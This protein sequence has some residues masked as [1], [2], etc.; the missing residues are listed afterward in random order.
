MTKAFLAMAAASTSVL[1]RGAL[2]ER[3]AR[4]LVYSGAP[5]KGL[6]ASHDDI[7]ISGAELETVAEAAGHFGGNHA[8]ARAE[9]RVIDQFAGPAVVDDRAAHRFD[10]LLRAMPPALLAPR[11]AE[12]IVVGKLPDRC[13]GAVAGPVAGLAL[14]HGVPAAYVLPVI[15]AAAQ[16]EMLLRP[17]D[18]SAQL[19]PA[20]RQA[21]GDDI[22][23]HRPMPDIGG[24]SREQRI[25]LLP[26]GAIV[27]ENFALCERA[28]TAAAAGSPGW[29]VGDPIGWIGDHQGRL[30][31]CQYHRDISGAGAV[32]A[33][34][35]VVSHLPYIARSRDG[36]I[37]DFRD[38]VGIAQTARPQTGQDLLQPVRL[39][40]DQIKVETAGLEVTQLVAEQIEIPARPRRQFIVGQTICL[41]LIFAPAARDDYRDRRQL[42]L[43][44]GRDTPMAGD[45]RALLVDQRRVRP[46][47]SADRRGDFVD[48]GF[49]VE[50]RVL[51]IGDEPFDRPALD[52]VGRPR[53]YGA[54][55]GGPRIHECHWLTSRRQRPSNNR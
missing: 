8:R 27:V 7:D 33:A 50:P 42:Q 52:A 14:A 40:A 54:R 51:Y 15:I 21:G 49:A 34:N 41:L 2:V 22:A 20:T 24:I 39:K 43:C 12:R 28:G 19:E 3:L 37:R 55:P 44:R 9:K 31:S 11:A 1:A 26:I 17:D 32:A 38:G 18:L 46:P 45:Q 5:G 16:R 6:P 29:I 23:V 25:G 35:Q 10:R 47:P 4:C 30:R 13:L 53:P 48:V 36:L